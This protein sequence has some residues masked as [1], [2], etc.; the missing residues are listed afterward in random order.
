M[1][2]GQALAS[3]D[4]VFND[5]RDAIGLLVNPDTNVAAPPTVD[6]LIDGR[7][8]L[9]FTLPLAGESDRDL[10]DASLSTLPLVV[11]TGQDEDR[12]DA[13]T[14]GDI[15]F[16]D[17]GRV[18]YFATKPDAGSTY[19]DL[20]R[21]AVT[22][23]G[24]GGPGDKT[25]GVV[26]PAGY[27]ISID[28][29][30][31]AKDT[32]S[33]PAGN[34]IVF[35]GAGGDRIDVGSGTNL[36]FGDSGFVDWVTTDGDATDIDAAGSIA[37]EVGGNDTVTTGHNGNNLV[38][39]G[40][41]TDTFTGGDGFNVILGDAGTIT[42]AQTDGPQFY[43]LKLT[44]GSIVTSAPGS[45]GHD[46]I[47]TGPG[48][49]IVFGGDGGDAITIGDGNN[50]VFGD[51]GGIEWSSD[52]THLQRLYSL[53]TVLGGVATGGTDT[54]TL[55]DGDAI[56]VGGEYGD[57]ISG[58]TGNNVILGDSGEIDAAPFDTH[59]YGAL[60]ITLGGIHTTE[61]KTGG[62]D[63]IQ[64]G[65]G[66]DV[67]IGGTGGD[68]II[69]GTVDPLHPGAI[70]AG[71][72]TSIVIGDDGEI[73]W[74][75]ADPSVLARIASTTPSD[76]SGDVI[77]LG[78][79]PA[80]VIGGAGKDDITG[81]ASTAIILGDSGEIDAFLAAP[82]HSAQFGDLPITLSSVKTIDDGGDT[83]TI[84]TGS[85]SNVIMGGAGHDEIDLGTG[86]GT[87]I[88]VG[89]EGEVYYALDGNPKDIAA[90]P[91]GNLWFTEQSG[92]RVGRISLTG[93]EREFLVR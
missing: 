60:P 9:H 30:I 5:A 69:L 35:G 7:P 18:L 33:V 52:A 71:T 82:D 81:G 65:N 27:A 21:Q 37:P 38:V 12:V 36:L 83:D 58:G 78:S 42:A 20:L 29:S 43:D 14:G 72:G 31:G 80:I 48:N 54:I 26:R 4:W 47:D 22:V 86:T 2:N 59:R 68:T 1:L 74:N 19:A 24:G 17:R 64:T 34:D 70:T 44:P 87:N 66:N 50:I 90:G 16:G 41:G 49:D 11:F 6:V 40:A 76:G 45:G 23:L 55:N 61:P 51:N 62:V 63:T 77:K 8:T 91:N 39:L 56:V 13:G 67:V 28:P 25:D 32:I 15:V 79:G 53:T 92:N 85:G 75:P 93:D 57:S 84:R 46:V 10:V 3:T 73:D 89:D 88:V